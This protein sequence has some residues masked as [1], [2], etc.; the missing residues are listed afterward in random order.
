MLPTVAAQCWW[1]WGRRPHCSLSVQG[2]YIVE[3]NLMINR[4]AIQKLLKTE[5]NSSMIRTNP[6]ISHFKTWGSPLY[7][8]QR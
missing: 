3:E 2:I 5:D 7:Q 4:E 8:A 6:Q 1:K